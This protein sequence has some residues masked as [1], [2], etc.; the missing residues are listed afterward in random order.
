MIDFLKTRKTNVKI[1]FEDSQSKEC[2]WVTETRIK[3]NDEQ[4]FFVSTCTGLPVSKLKNIECLRLQ[5]TCE[6]CNKPMIIRL[7]MQHGSDM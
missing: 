1:V 5:P 4:A 3:P 6:F 2:E 7:R